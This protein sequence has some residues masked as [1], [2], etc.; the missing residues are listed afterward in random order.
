MFQKVPGP[1]EAAIAPM[2][3][4]TASPGG[5]LR[6]L[7]TLGVAL[8]PLLL[9]LACSK[10][11]DS[12]SDPGKP[13]AITTAPVDASTVTGRPVSFAVTATGE[14]TLRYQWNKDGVDILGAISSTYTIFNPKMQD[15][16]KYAVTVTNPNGKVTSSAATLTVA[17]AVTFS[18]PMGLATDAA[19]NT[20]VSD[21]DDHTIWKVSATNQKT[22]LAGASGQAG[23]VDAKGGA[24]RFNTPGGLALDA[25][26]NLLVADTGNHTIRS[27]APDGTVTTLAGTAGQVGSDDGNGAL[28]RFNSPFGLAVGGGGVYIS[29]TQ[30]H[31]IRLLAP[32]GDVTTFAGLAGKPGQ[33]DGPRASAQFN[34]PNGLALAGNGTLYLADYGNSVI[35]AISAS[36]AV[37]LLAGQ[38]AAHGLTDGTGAVA[39]FYQPLGLS[40][41]AS[42]NLY[43]ADSANHTIRRVTAAGAVSVAAGSATLG[44][45]DSTGSSAQF[46]LPCGV[47]V[48]A[49]GNVVVADTNNHIL[50]SLTAAGVVTTPVVP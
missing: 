43:V 12:A 16:G 17:Q 42:G 18:A 48:N 35:R 8:L 49:A 47:A 20:Y 33:V 21:M 25:S 22:L 7:R 37:S 32:N 38:Y 6:R 36:G 40:L 34:Q 50:R 15:A 2:R 46:F 11:K 9:V 26:G 5:F 45:V 31:T 24:A 39:Q 44:N 28:A 23:A 27:I 41:D 29:D 14:I 30:N 3:P 19:G 13:P 1:G 4:A 10:H